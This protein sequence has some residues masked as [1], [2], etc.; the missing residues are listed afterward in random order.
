MRMAKYAATAAGSVPSTA[1]SAASKFV[2][3]SMKGRLAVGAGGAALGYGAYKGIQ[4]IGRKMGFGGKEKKA[5]DKKTDKELKETGRQR[6]VTALAAEAQRE[7][8][9]RGERAGKAIGSTAGALGGAALGRKYIGGPAGT[10][11]GAAAGYL[12][13]GR[14]GGELGT[15]LDIRKNA[16]VK[17]ALS[18]RTVREAADKTVRQLAQEVKNPATREAALEKLKRHGRNLG[19]RGRSTGNWMDSSKHTSGI[20]SKAQAAAT[21][22]RAGMKG[23][24]EGLKA[25][26]EGVSEGTLKKIKTGS[27]NAVA[28]M[29]FTKALMKMAEG[30]AGLGA[31]ESQ[32]A[33]PTDGQE[34]QPRNYMQAEQMGQQAQSAN[35]AGYYREQ[36]QQSS[37]QMQGMQQQV[38]EAQMQLQGLQQSAEQ[39]NQQVQQAAQAAQQAHD[40]ATEQ[41]MQAA[42]ARIGAQKMRQQF[43]QLASQDPQALGEE[44]MGP[45]PEEMAAQQQQQAMQQEAG[46]PGA[47]GGQAPGEAPP[48]AAGGA[49]AAPEGPAGQAP[50]PQTAPGAAPPQGQPDMNAAAG[51]M[52]GADMQGAEGASQLKTGA[53]NPRMLGAAVGGGL[54]AGM[55]VVQGARAPGLRQKVQDMQSQPGGFHQASQLAKA[56]AASAQAGLAE[57]HPGMSA[58][59]GGLMGA[60]LGAMMGPSLAQKATNIRKDLPDAARGM[61]RILGMR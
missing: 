50:A 61:G 33:A 25:V 12:T 21:N 7:K 30:E 9:R 13:G 39:A 23:S 36:L 34:M 15:E 26:R 57:K 19:H 6:G 29:R 54:G 55:S 14:A 5:A 17:E 40:M 44:A 24:P 43:L 10:L 48:D 1:A 58:L 28:S 11:G 2:P 42:K 18:F 20:Q 4:H 51:G 38:Q 31:E 47:E 46:M 41:T 52:P 59:K 60:G 3:K 37:Q 16:A 49:P 22:L 32:M 56:Q 27:F 35:E 8:G 53:M 45:S